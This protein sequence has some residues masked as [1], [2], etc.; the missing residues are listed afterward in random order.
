MEPDAAKKI[1][2]LRLGAEENDEI[3]SVESQVIL[4]LLVLLEQ[5]LQ[6]KRAGRFTGFVTI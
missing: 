1:R 2:E 3:G 6:G 5:H 4:R